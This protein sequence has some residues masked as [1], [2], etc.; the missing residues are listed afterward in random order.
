M[1]WM[2]QSQ[3]Q[4]SMRRPQFNMTDDEFNWYKPVAVIL[5]PASKR[6]LQQRL[7]QV[8]VDEFLLPSYQSSLLPPWPFV[9][10]YSAFRR[11]INYQSSD[12][13]R[14]VYRR[15]ELLAGHVERRLT[16]LARM[17]LVAI[18][19]VTKIN[20]QRSGNNRNQEQQMPEQ[21]KIIFLNITL[22]SVC[23]LMCKDWR[24]FSFRRAFPNS[25]SLRFLFR[26]K[27]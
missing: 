10:D 16:S 2:T 27:R 25:Q 22:N 26:E 13:L 9:Q 5:K 18:P 11:W 15:Y 24:D 23:V 6:D 14:D 7:L 17:G 20:R 12:R 3:M 1:V 21:S 19:K 8:N 4:T